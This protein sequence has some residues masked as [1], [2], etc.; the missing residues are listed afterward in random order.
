MV[1]SEREDG[2]VYYEV[3]ETWYITGYG[4]LGGDLFG[5]VGDGRGANSQADGFGNEK[6]GGFGHGSG[7]GANG[8]GEGSTSNFLF[9]WL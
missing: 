8:S 9:G 1:V 3:E 4:L 2:V 5:M 7:E 6:G